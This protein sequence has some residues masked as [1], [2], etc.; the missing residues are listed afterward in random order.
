MTN[1]KTTH[2]LNRKGTSNYAL[3]VVDE[4]DNKVDFRR[5]EFYTGPCLEER[6]MTVDEARA[7]YREMVNSRVKLNHYDAEANQEW[8]PVRES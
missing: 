2:R 6:Q 4:A 3:F 8:V 1:Q 7:L 5:F